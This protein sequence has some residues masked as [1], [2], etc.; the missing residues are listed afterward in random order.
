MG[1][2]QGF[3][4]SG[5]GWGKVPSVRGESDILLGEGIFLTGEANLRRSDFD[6]FNLLTILTFARNKQGLDS[7]QI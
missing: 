5:T 2:D 4:I 1:W 3:P 6:D 7:L